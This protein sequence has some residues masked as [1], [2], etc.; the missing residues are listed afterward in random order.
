MVLEQLIY[1]EV[2]PVL[3]SLFP[4]IM[5]MVYTT[6]AAADEAILNRSSNVTGQN[7]WGLPRLKQIEMVYAVH[8]PINKASKQNVRWELYGDH[9]LSLFC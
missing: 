5:R 8:C 7:A 3:I 1:P 4:W 6:G 2:C 9:L